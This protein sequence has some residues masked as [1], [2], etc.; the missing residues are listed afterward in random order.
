M[1]LG[2]VMLDIEG[3]TLTSEEREKL[4]HPCAAG[5]ILFTRNFTSVD[6]LNDLTS[7]IHALRDPHLLIA[8]DHEGGRVQRFREGFTHLPPA[9]AFG[10]VYDRD[11]RRGLYLADL[12]GWLMASELRAVGVDFSFAPVLDL[13]HGLSGVIG[14]RAFHRNPEAVA[15]LA[16]AYIRGMHRA[17]MQPIAK[18]FPGHGGVQGDSHL[19][20]PMDLRT[21][22]EI[23]KHDL[24]PF[25]LLVK[26]GLAGIMPAHVQ[27]SEVD[28][29]PAGFS[30]FWLQEI[31]R[32]RLKFMGAIISDDLSMAGAQIGDGYVDRANA[33]LT[34]GCDM[35]LIC[36]HPD[37]ASKVLCALEGTDINPVLQVR[38]IRLH[39]QGPQL[40][41]MDL[42]KQPEWGNAVRQLTA[43]GNMPNLEFNI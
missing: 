13:A 4:L 9:A 30:S 17:G 32:K 18:H 43:L 11:R 20:L 26:S 33:A 8:V 6:Q 42:Q 25:D 15:A 7:E 41:M 39:G 12:S 16:Q 34:A 36:N 24:R 27:Y 14:D 37:G 5:V 29:L 31:L 10:A 28:K 1:S 23:E 40:S 2:P 19:T 3:T 35:L 22:S 21:L 38:L